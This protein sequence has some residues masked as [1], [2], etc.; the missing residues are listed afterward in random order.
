MRRFDR[1]RVPSERPL[2]RSRFI[3]R[4]VPYRHLITAVLDALAWPVALIYS[5]WLRYEF[6]SSQIRWDDLLLLAAAAAVFQVALGRWQGLYTGRWRF[7]SFEE[8]AGLVMSVVG[9]TVLVFVTN[10]SRDPHFVPSSAVLGAGLVALVMMSAM[11][12][13][14]RLYLD[15]MRRPRSDHVQRTIVYGAGDAGHQLV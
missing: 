6:A 9:T 7:G 10:H 2:F 12:Y 8:V 11:R 14:W 4:L 3:E 5:S 1:A 13:G 15:S